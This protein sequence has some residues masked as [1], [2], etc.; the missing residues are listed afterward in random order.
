[1]FNF[2]ATVHDDIHAIR[3]GQVCRL[4]IPDT[5]LEPDDLGPDVVGIFDNR[6]SVVGFSED[7]DDSGY[8]GQCLEPPPLPRIRHELPWSAP[9]QEA[10]V[11]HKTT[12]DKPK[13]RT[14]RQNK[15]TLILYEN[16]RPSG[17]AAGD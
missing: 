3:L 14:R 12:S 8:D 11:T 6:G 1:M 2:H 5:Q 10:A 7:V 4:F 15:R 9:T 13:R 16:E 17:G